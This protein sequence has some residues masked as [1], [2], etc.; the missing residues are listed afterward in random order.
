VI[1][2]K[3]FPENTGDKC[4]PSFSLPGKEKEETFNK[5]KKKSNSKP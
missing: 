4:K 3:L 2:V 1:S 5:L